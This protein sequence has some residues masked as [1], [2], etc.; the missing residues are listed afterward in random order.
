MAKSKTTVQLSEI[1]QKLGISISTVSIVLNGRGDEMRI[2]KITQE[3]IRQV[4]KGM[5]YQP[6]IYARRLRKMQD[7]TYPQSIGI[8]WCNHFSDETMGRFFHGA[9]DGL[10]D[11]DKRVEFALHIFDSDHLFELKELLTSNYFSAMVIN[12]A[13]DADVEFLSGQTFRVPVV[14]SGRSADGISCVYVDNY[15]LGKKCAKLF[16]DNGCKTMGIIGYGR[17]STGASL[18]LTGFMDGCQAYGMEAPEAYRIPTETIDIDGGYQAMAQLLSLPHQPQGIIVMTDME[19]I[20]SVLYMKEHHVLQENRYALMTYGYSKTLATMAP[21]M[22]YAHIMIEDI[23]RQSIQLLQMLLNNN[24][25]SPINQITSPE[26]Y[27][28]AFVK[29]I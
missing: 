17:R 3:R 13:S 20:G 2:S 6:N 18:R 8:F 14:L 4:A 5:N 23:A 28:G 9:Y 26:I 21:T 1:A 25:T 29:H 10:K 11:K 27:Y 7:G 15:S 16:A 24:I 12:G 22:A 19:A